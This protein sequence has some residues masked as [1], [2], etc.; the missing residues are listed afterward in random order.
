MKA[1]SRSLSLME[2]LKDRLGDLNI[3]VFYGA[4]IGHIANNM[5][6]PIGV[7]A[8]LDA[9]TGEIILLEKAELGATGAWHYRNI[10]PTV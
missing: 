10:E 7:K 2:T 4:S 3:P 6:L 9:N 8:Q 1:G 5:T